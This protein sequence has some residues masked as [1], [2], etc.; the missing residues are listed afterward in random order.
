MKNL[1]NI[2]FILLLSMTFTSIAKT[3]KIKI[4]DTPHAINIAGKQRMLTQKML[5]NYTL[6]VMD[7][8]VASEKEELANDIKKFTASLEA[9]IKYTESI[10]YNIPYDNIEM[11]WEMLQILLSTVPSEVV[12][13]ELQRGLDILLE[14][15]NK[16][17]IALTKRSGQNSSKIINMSGIQRM[18][19]QRL[20][21]LYFIKIMGIDD[22]DFKKKLSATIK[23]FEYNQKILERYKGNTEEINKKLKK[24]KMSFNFFKDL[25][26]GKIKTPMPL[27]INLN[28][29]AILKNMDEITHQYMNMASK[30]YWG[31]SP[32]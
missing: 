26:S 9:L 4:M 1:S 11:Y 23:S 24:V 28:S 18:Y 19:S 20:A 5:K 6:L 10:N 2:L 21:N 7:K 32:I 15:T 3:E 27:L 30:K 16:Y 25:A 31:K 17:T 22:Q 12:I 8:G 29:N 13:P 14:D